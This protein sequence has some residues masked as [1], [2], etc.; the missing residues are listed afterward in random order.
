MRPRRLLRPRSRRR[1]RRRDARA[2]AA[3]RAG[4]ARLHR[5]RGL[6]TWLMHRLAPA[7]VDPLAPE[8]PLA[9]VFSPLVGTPLTTSAKFAVVAKSPLTGLL[10]DALASSHFAIAGKLTGHDAIVVR[11]ACA[12]PSVLLVDGDGPRPRARRGD[13]WGLPAAEAEERLRERLGKAWRVAVDRPGRRAA[14]ATRRSRHDG[15]HA[16]RGGLGAVLGAKLLKAVAVRGATKVAPGRP[17]AVLA[18]RATCASAR[19]ARRPPSTASSARW[20]TCWRSTR[21]PRCPP[22]TSRR[23]RSPRRRGSPPRTSPSCAASR[24]TAARRARSAASTST[25]TGGGRHARRVRER[26]RAGAAVR[27][28]RTGRRA[29]GQRALRRAGPRHDLGGRHDRLGDGVRRARPD[30]RAVAA[31]RR[32]RRAAAR[33]RRDR[34]REGLGACWRRARGA[35]AEIVGA[36]LDGVRPRT[37]RGSSCPATSRGRCRRWRS[38]WPSTRAA[39]TT[40]ARAPT[41]PTCRAAT[42]GSPAAPRTSPPRIETEDRAAVMDSLILCKFLRGVFEDPFA[43]WAAPARRRHRL[44]RRRRRAGGDRAPDRARQAGVQRPRGLDARGRHAA[45]RPLPRG[46]ARDGIRPERRASPRERLDAMIAGVLRGS[47]PGPG[48]RPARDGADGG[49]PAPV[50]ALTQ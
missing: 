37:S 36:G 40:T 39:P 49:S 5:R 46:A 28:V 26:L 12:E 13:L 4:A 11:G 29:R 41:R 32:R 27:R 21:S 6:G 31:L 25:R 9:F 17:A 3:R 16:G 47:R 50:V 30:R 7:G 35:A 15:R 24:A 2:A 34:R 18:P 20:P 1:P 33:A 19:S 22:A 8:A 48:R 45:A 38:A 23:P 42:T 14:A 43:E 10:N 44:G